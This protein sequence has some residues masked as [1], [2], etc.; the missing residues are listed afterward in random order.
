MTLVAVWMCSSVLAMG[1]QCDLSHP[2]ALAGRRCSGSV[3]IFHT[4][5]YYTELTAASARTNHWHRCCRHSHRAGVDRRGHLDGLD[6][7]LAHIDKGRCCSRFRVSLAVSPAFE[8]NTM[9]RLV[10]ADKNNIQTDSFR[11]LAHSSLESG[12]TIERLHSLYGYVR[13]LDAN[14]DILFNHLRNYPEH[15]SA[16]SQPQHSLRRRFHSQST[17]RP[18]QSLTVHYDSRRIPRRPKIQALGLWPRSA[19][20]NE[21]ALLPP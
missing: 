16:R 11:R 6:T 13:R 14:R 3:R 10:F 8:V 18:R 1:L 20:R 17:F 15:S 19:R 12:L 21:R 9:F 5:I 4:S 2:W 7:P